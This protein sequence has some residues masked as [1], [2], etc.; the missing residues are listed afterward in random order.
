MGGVLIVDDSPSFR[1][2]CARLLIASGLVVA[3]QAADA[4]AALHL[5]RTLRPAAVVLDVHLGDADG[6]QVAGALRAL[7]PAPRVVLISSD[8][9]AGDDALVRRY[10]A[11][12]FVPKAELDDHD[13]AALLGVADAE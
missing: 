13:L 8:A 1:A 2:L 6:W 5:A 9:D 3:G 10:G 12:G 7:D 4:P 11:H